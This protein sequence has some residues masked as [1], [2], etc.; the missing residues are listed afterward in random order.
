MPT[1][2]ELTTLFGV[3]PELPPPLPR[4][5]QSFAQQK[6]AAV[7]PPTASTPKTTLLFPWAFAPREAVRNINPFLSLKTGK[8]MVVIAA[9][10]AGMI[11]F[12]RFGEGVFTEWPMA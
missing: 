5:R 7:T 4:K 9:V 11:S 12:Y 6:A 3:L 2:T 8:K 1:L 10:D